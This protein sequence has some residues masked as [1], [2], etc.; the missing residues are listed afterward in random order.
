MGQIRDV[1]LPNSSPD[2]VQMTSQKAGLV[3]P[4]F[5]KVMYIANNAAGVTTVLPQD[6]NK[7]YIVQ[8][9]NF[10]LSNNAGTT[11]TLCNLT[12]TEFVEG[13]YIIL[14]TLKVTAS[15]VN[16]DQARVQGLN[17]PVKPGTAVNIATDNAPENVTLQL[18]Y[19]EITI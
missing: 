3:I 1:M 5:M 13:K 2:V 10:T 6:A 18:F 11:C 12:L 4:P 8:G 15:Q 19:S 9:Y 17:I 14:D 7:I 16:K